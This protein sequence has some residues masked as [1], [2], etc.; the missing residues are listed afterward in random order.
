MQQHGKKTGGRQAV[1]SRLKPRATPDGG[2]RPGADGEWK[3]KG[4]K[5]AEPARKRGLASR[6]AESPGQPRSDDE[7]IR[8]W[9]AER[10]AWWA[11]QLP[12]E[13]EEDEYADPDEYDDDDEDDAEDDQDENDGI[14]LPMSAPSEGAAN[15]GAH[16][17]TDADCFDAYLA[18]V[19]ARRDNVQSG[20]GIGVATGLPSL[21]HGRGAV[22]QITII[23][24]RTQTGKTSLA[25]QISVAA[26]RSDRELAVAYHLMDDMTQFDLFDQILC[27]E[28]RVDYGSYTAGSLTKDEQGRVEAAIIRLRQD[29][30]PRMR[31]FDLFPNERGWGLSGQLIFAACRQ[32]MGQVGAK[33]VLV[34]LDMFNDM[35]HP[36]ASA[37]WDE[38]VLSTVRRAESDP[39]RW[40]L[41]Q[42]LELR[43]LSHGVTPGGWPVLALCEL[44]KPTSQRDEDPTVED[45]LGGVEL[46]YK[47]KRVFFL[48]PD[49]R[50]DARKPV[51]PVTLV[52]KKARHAQLNRL[53]LRFHHTQFRFE[54]VNDVRVSGGASDNTVSAGQR[55]AK[56]FAGK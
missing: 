56:R 28:A 9:R 44:R 39:D 11:E 48:V 29:V 19:R 21:D 41:E 34:V 30:F 18:H 10:R 24:G 33:R 2:E 13:E 27:S 36:K 6:L 49:P 54:E 37:G 46:T 20:G 22:E 50:A 47:A 5:R 3:G 35:P 53:P 40:R 26:L 8:Q 31:T 52:V 17:P 16:T 45:L 23:G 12:H 51:V 4:E 32:F 38:E 15:S 14:G 1:R 42:L 25:T 43:R 55:K 7:E